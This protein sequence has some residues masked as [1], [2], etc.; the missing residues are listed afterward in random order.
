MGWAKGGGGTTGDSLKVDASGGGITSG[1]SIVEDQDGTDSALSISTTAVQVNESL[2]TEL[3]TNGS[4]TGSATGWTL[5]SGWAYASNAVNK[6]V[7]GS[8]GTL[9]QAITVAAS[10][11]YK[12]SF[13]ISNYAAGYVF[14]SLGGQTTPT[15]QENGAHIQYIYTSS[16]AGTLTFTT[17]DASVFTID[18]VSVKATTVGTDY[19]ADTEIN[20]E[21]RFAAFGT[22]TVNPG[23]EIVI[24]P[25]NTV[26]TGSSGS[27]NVV[28][29]S[30]AAGP[31]LN[32][33]SV[34]ASSGVYVASNAEVL[35]STSLGLGSAIPLS[36][37]STTSGSGGKDSG[38]KRNSAAIIYATDGSTGA[39]ALGF[40]TANGAS[41]TWGQATELLTVAASNTSTT[42]ANLLPA[43]S[44][45]DAVTYRN[46]VA[47]N[48]AGTF[49]IGDGTTADRFGSGIDHSVDVNGVVLLQHNPADTNPYGAVQT[50]AAKIVITWAGGDPA[51]ANGRIR[52]TIFYHTYTAATS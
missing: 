25:V 33:A 10:T 38:L 40:A 21:L 17:T 23:A 50:A 45:I 31:G 36:W 7:Q 27:L 11:W 24:R 41:V 18:S 43:N 46:T 20:R 2:G 26:A 35:G 47:I 30:G 49:S 15:S 5:G 34:V 37:S 13:T 42:S 4:F 16:T 52:F 39:G 8:S 1:L 9:T 28:N 51:D 3:V 6:A 14:V 12:I 48:A 22:G 32:I 44:I 19:A 29:G